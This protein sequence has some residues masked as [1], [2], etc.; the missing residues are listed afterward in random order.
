M[1]L[2]YQNLDVLE[3]Y[4]KLPFNIYSNKESA[5]KSLKEN[6]PI[7]IYP[8]LSKIIKNDENINILDLGCGIGWFANLLSYNFNRINVT[9]VDFNSV[10]IDFA[11]KI[12]DQLNLKTNFIVEDLF[13]VEFSDKFDLISSLGVLHHTN[14]CFKGIEKI[15]ELSPRYFL[16]GL[17]HKYGRKPFLEHFDNL[18]LK[19][20]DLKKND[21]ENA[22]FEEY[23]KLDKR[24]SDETHLRSWFKDQ[25]L[26][27]KET[28]H[29][30][31]EILP[32]I[33]TKY[34]IISTSLNKFEQI[35]NLEQIVEEEEK[36]LNFGLQKL[37]NN[38]YFPGFFIIFGERINCV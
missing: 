29:T 38:I 8:P 31:A 2:T 27:P 5:I 22:L 17:Y 10:A 30:L 11:N 25:V 7:K 32:I 36:W 19:F 6:D 3:F 16:I 4:R 13:K 33:K 15:I 20:K 37:R 1:N 34:K 23:K 26:H 24:S 9:G 35:H 12:K 28:Q 18:K 14:N 21:L